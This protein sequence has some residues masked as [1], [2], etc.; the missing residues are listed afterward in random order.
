MEIM[1]AKQAHPFMWLGAAFAMIVLIAA[2]PL[3]S[4]LIS[5]GI[6]GALG[7]ELNEGGAHPCPFMGVDLGRTLVLMFV[8]GW[9][10]FVTLPLGA[11]ALAGWLIIA[12][13]V[14]F[15]WWRRRR[16]QDSPTMF[17]CSTDVRS[18]D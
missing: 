3:I 7:C 17:Q 15:F 11:A 5:A 1:N 14:T 12:C 16:H 10:A 13:I 4:V 6:A 8:L 18:K 2:A 9:L